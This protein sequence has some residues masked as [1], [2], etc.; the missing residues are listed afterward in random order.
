MGIKKKFSKK[1]W[2][3]KR[4]KRFLFVDDLLQSNL[5]LFL[6]K[7]EVINLLGDEFN[8]AN[9]NKWTYYIGKSYRLISFTKSKLF[10]YFN[11]ND[12]VFKFLKK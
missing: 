9:S 1:N 12:E 8:D 3:L 11:E 5:L 4:E 6:N 2:I 10:I 7:K